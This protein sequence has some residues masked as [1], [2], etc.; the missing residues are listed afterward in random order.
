[1]AHLFGGFPAAFF[2]GY[3]REWPRPDGH[4]LRQKLYDLYHLLNHANLFG[5]GYWGQAQSLIT[6]L[7]G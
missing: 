5:G 2:R 4:R 7:V 6:E 1:M 3:E